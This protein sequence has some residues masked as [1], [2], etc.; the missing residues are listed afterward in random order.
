MNPYL[1]DIR[2]IVKCLRADVLALGGMLPQTGDDL[3]IS[4]IEAARLLL[5]L[6]HVAG[7]VQDACDALAAAAPL[8]D[9]TAP[10]PGEP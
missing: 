5:M 7:M 4:G 8:P 6:H 3:D 1:R 2:Q 9:G 10:A